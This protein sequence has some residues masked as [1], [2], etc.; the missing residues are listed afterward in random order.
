MRRRTSVTNVAGYGFL[1][2][3]RQLAVTEAAAVGF[4]EPERFGRRPL[5]GGVDAVARHQRRLAAA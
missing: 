3:I 2:G 1:E 5:R 4:V